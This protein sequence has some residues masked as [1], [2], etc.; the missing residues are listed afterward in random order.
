MIIMSRALIGMSHKLAA[1]NYTGNLWTRFE[2]N[3]VDAN[4]VCPLYPQDF[5]QECCC[6]ILV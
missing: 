3:L 5:Y 6:Y 1:C 2:Y 4:R